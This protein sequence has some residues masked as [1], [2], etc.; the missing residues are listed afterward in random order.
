MINM[1]CVFKFLPRKRQENRKQ[2]VRKR[3]RRNKREIETKSWPIFILLCFF[4]FLMGLF[5]KKKSCAL[6]FFRG[7]EGGFQ[8]KVTV[9]EKGRWNKVPTRVMRGY[10]LP[11]SSLV[12]TC[13]ANSWRNQPIVSPKATDG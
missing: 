5:K 3:V 7:V 4:F 10:N 11:K 13:E 12:T 1:R 8:S 6:I 2:N 9:R